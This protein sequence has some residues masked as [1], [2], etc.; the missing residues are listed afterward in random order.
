MKFGDEK[1]RTGLTLLPEA[2]VRPKLKFILFFV[3]EKIEFIYW[4]AVIYSVRSTQSSRDSEF[5]ALSPPY[6]ERMK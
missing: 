5:F 3:G 1:F 6:K 2:H 4:T